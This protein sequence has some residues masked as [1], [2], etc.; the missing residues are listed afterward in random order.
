MRMALRRG[1]ILIC[2]FLCGWVCG[3]TSP[4]KTYLLPQPQQ[5]EWDYKGSRVWVNDERIAPPIWIATHTEL[6]KWTKLADL[7]GVD[8]R[9]ALG[10]SAPFA[11]A[12]N[13]SLIVSGGC[14]FPDKPVAEG[15]TKRYYDEI[16][17]LGA[18]GWKM[19]GHLPT[20][21]AYGAAVSTP[22]GVIC[23]GGN[24]ADRSMK[25]VIRL[26]VST[27]GDALVIDT[28]PALPVT[29]DNMAAAYADGQLYVAGG[30]A[31]GAPCRSL[32][33]LDLTQDSLGWEA[34]PDFPGP[35]RVQP[36]LIAKGDR[37]AQQLYLAGGFQPIEGEQEALLPTE[38]LTFDTATRTWRTECELPPLADGAPRTLTGGNAL[39]W[40]A[41]RI[42]YFGG[43]N[44]QK[45]ADAV[46][47]P[48]RMKAAEAAADTVTLDSLRAEATQYLRHPVEWYRFNTDLLMYDTET[49][50][51][52]LLGSHEPLARAGAGAVLLNQQIIV[53]CGELKPG[54][55]TPQVNQ[56]GLQAICHC[57]RCRYGSFC[58]K[59]RKDR[60]GSTTSRGSI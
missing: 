37:P 48:L 32:Y 23:I 9:E 43:V 60:N 34:L 11:G 28:L 21:V 47:R 42:L 46:N 5:G 33:H 50:R 17:Q 1:Y 12:H 36:V 18:E 35:C 4:C 59:E 29:M 3:A 44:Y 22:E 45:F 13:G 51:W 55:R 27:G 10:V 41:H 38:L 7:P 26:A 57:N 6:S 20:P 30:N 24:N 15:G 25:E 8:Q 2:L 39:L 31:D 14:N 54:I 52:E 58:G 53:I 49:K 40:N 56:L 19:I 16:F